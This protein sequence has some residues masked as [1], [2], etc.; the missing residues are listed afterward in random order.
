MGM[1]ATTH[2]LVWNRLWNPNKITS[3]WNLFTQGNHTQVQGSI[4]GC[5]NCS[6]T[7]LL[8]DSSQEKKT[9]QILYLVS[10]ISTPNNARN[11]APKPRSMWGLS[12]KTQ[13]RVPYPLERL[14]VPQQLTK[15]CP[16]LESAFRRDSGRHLKTSGTWWSGA[17][18]L[19]LENQHYEDLG[20]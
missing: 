11:C 5:Y 15:N 2:I 17:N 10:Q 4:G 12:L 8:W 18:F 6:H 3:P 14:N 1:W 9:L 20:S 7:V 19:S 13:L 16:V